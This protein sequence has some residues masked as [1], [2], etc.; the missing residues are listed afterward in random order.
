MKKSVN[1]NDYTLFAE[2][3]SSAVDYYLEAGF[4]HF[5]ICGPATADL[6]VFQEQ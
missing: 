6:Y 3:H 1:S 2:R 4:G 5:V